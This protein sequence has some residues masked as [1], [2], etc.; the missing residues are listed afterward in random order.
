MAKEKEEKANVEK[1]QISEVEHNEV[2]EVVQPPISPYDKCMQDHIGEF[3][4]CSA[5]GVWTPLS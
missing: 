2:P 3:G 1:K 4:S 5:D